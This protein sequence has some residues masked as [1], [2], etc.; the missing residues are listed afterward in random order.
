[1]KIDIDKLKLVPPSMKTSQGLELCTYGDVSSEIENWISHHSLITN[2]NGKYTNIIIK[3]IALSELFLI[4]HVFDYMDGFSPNLNKKL[5]IGHF[6]NL[7]LA[8]AFYEMNVANTLI[9][10]YGDAH[11]GELSIPEAWKLIQKLYNTF[12]FHPNQEY[13]ASE[14]KYEG[15]ALIDENEGDYAGTKIFDVDNEKI[16]GIKS[17]GTTTYFYQDVCLA[18]KLKSAHGHNFPPKT[19][20]LTGAEQENHFRLLKKLYP[21][22]FS[23]YFIRL[24]SNTLLFIA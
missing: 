2:K 10:I 12:K 16:V 14:M 3:D 15:D 22:T 17:N 9:S 20:Y 19:L 13:L 23:S 7:V 18:E 5:H 21:Y 1:M 4:P 6:S 11:E 24:K 8:K